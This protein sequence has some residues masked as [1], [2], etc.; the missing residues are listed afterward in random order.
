MFLCLLYLV[1]DEAKEA[2]HHAEGAAV[3]A[4]DARRAVDRDGQLRGDGGG[5]RASAA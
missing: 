4:R 1:T 3:V 5:R 2:A